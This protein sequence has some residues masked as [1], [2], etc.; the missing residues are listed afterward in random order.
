MGF[1]AAL[2]G[3]PAGPPTRHHIVYYIGYILGIL[4]G[5]L[6]DLLLDLLKNPFT[7]TPLTRTPLTVAGQVLAEPLAHNADSEIRMFDRAYRAAT[8]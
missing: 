2:H 5:I 3:R 8:G 6:L 7:R 1:G 4:L